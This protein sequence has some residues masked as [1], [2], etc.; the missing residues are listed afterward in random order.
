MK[1]S[2]FQFSNPTLESLEYTI[3]KDF[4]EDKFNGI[5]V[6]AETSIG[7]L[8]DKTQTSTVVGLKVEVGTHDSTSPFFARIA[9]SSEFHWDTDL[10]EKMLNNL[11]KY[12][13]PALLFSYIRP[14]IANLTNSSNYPPFNLPFM[15]FNESKSSKTE[16]ANYNEKLSVDNK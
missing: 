14:H 3:N 2:K 10:N 6:N 15:D 11:L 1:E 12:N 7:K 13:A 8:K 4:L 16:N 5:E 9:M